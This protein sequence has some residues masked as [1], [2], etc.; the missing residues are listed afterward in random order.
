VRAQGD[1]VGNFA[2]GM[3]TMVPLHLGLLPAGTT[4]ARVNK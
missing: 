3:I 1:P 4:G 2:Q